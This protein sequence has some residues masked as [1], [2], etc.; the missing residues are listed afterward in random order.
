M[1]LR[2][3]ATV[4]HEEHEACVL[5]HEKNEH[6]ILRLA[7]HHEALLSDIRGERDTPPSGREGPIRWRRR[8]RRAGWRPRRGEA[9]GCG[10]GGGQ[11][12]D[13]EPTTEEATS[14][15]AGGVFV[16]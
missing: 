15:E 13:V 14:G 7:K 1:H 6:E 9:R 12:G 2:P 3:R 8:R 5:H 10:R 11:R 16:F 4:A